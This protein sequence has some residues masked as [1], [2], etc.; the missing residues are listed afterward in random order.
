MPA[1]DHAAMPKSFHERL[2]TALA[3]GL[4]LFFWC[5]PAR[6]GGGSLSTL[7]EGSAGVQNGGNIFDI[8]VTRPGGLTIT[9]FDLNLGGLP[10]PAAFRLDV[11]VTSGSFVGKDA[12]PGAWTLVASATAQP[13]ALNIPVRVDTADFF[14]GEG[15]HGLALYISGNGP[16]YTMPGGAPLSIANADLTLRFGI[17][18]PLLFAGGN[19]LPRIWNGTIYY[20]AAP[21]Q[22]ATYGVGRVSS[23]GANCVPRITASGV[24]SVS[25]PAE[26]CVFGWRVPSHQ[27][28]LLLYSLHGRADL[29]F[30][31]GRLR[32]SPPI[33]RTLP[34]NS[35]GLSAGIDYS[36]RFALEFGA[37]ARG[38]LGGN[39]S[40]ALLWPGTVVNCQWW[41]RDPGFTPPFD[42]LLSDG[43]E[44]V[45]GT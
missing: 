40:S 28:G 11:Y 18:K 3:F 45:V 16:C 13:L 30:S 43:L 38:Q 14:L 39:P 23:L 34:V 1:A 6:A 26:F 44:F 41:G 36:G 24:L 27:N 35:G 32:L 31:G 15:L 19:F 29:P 9:G 5:A 2:R 21:P 42:A 7:F 25:T 17:S 37:F 10:P 4:A 22:L 12:L 20:D 8:L 33:R